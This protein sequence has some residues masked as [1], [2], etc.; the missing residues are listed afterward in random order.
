MEV[1][2]AAEPRR[3]HL[4]AVPITQ[5]TRLEGRARAGPDDQEQKAKEGAVARH[6]EDVARG[7]RR[8]VP[9][10]HRLLEEDLRAD[11][12]QHHR[13]LRHERHARVE[14]AVLAARAAEL[15]RDR[16]DSVA[17]PKTV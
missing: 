9:I 13:W 6:E 5:L 10:I 16:E 7:K 2:A 8:L 12:P 11:V 3:M 4:E 14:A 17:E 15:E 1:E